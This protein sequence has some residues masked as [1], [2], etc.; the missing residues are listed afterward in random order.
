MAWVGPFE[1]DRV[2]GSLGP[3]RG[4]RLEDLNPSAARA[5]G[6]GGAEAERGPGAWGRI[7]S[8]APSPG[9]LPRVGGAAWPGV[10]PSPGPRQEAGE[11]CWPAPSHPLAQGGR[12]AGQA[13]AS[14]LLS[15]FARNVLAAP[16]PTLPCRPAPHPPP[17]V[18]LAPS[19]ERTSIP[20][21]LRPAPVGSQPPS[22]PTRSPRDPSRSLTSPSPAHRAPRSLPGV[23]MA[24]LCDGQTT[25]GPRSGQ[26]GDGTLAR[27]PRQGPGPGERGR[28]PV[29][30]LREEVL[31]GDPVRAGP[32]LG[33]LG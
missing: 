23:N 33:L 25:V 22:C 28:E 13:R 15:Q 32:R 31:R 20:S 5:P 26:K 30:F 24:H 4:P 27:T 16:R 8:S 18:L 3:E 14:G 29:G 19:P 6:G 10:C 7:A 17:Q 11:L 21:L 12:S 2:A 9:S 1:Q